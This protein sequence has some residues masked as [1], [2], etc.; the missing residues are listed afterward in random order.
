MLLFK[1]SGNTFDS[2]IANQKHAFKGHPKNWEAGEIILISKNKT[3]CKP[4]EKQIQYIMFL[5]NIRQTNHDE[6]EKYWPNN[7]KRWKYI[8]DCSSCLNLQKS[9]NILELVGQ[10]F[11]H[12]YG[13]VQTFKKKDPKHEVLLLNFL[14]SINALD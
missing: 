11:F 14:K 13:R 5:D 9:F 10:E 3:F 7:Q 1:T 12:D 2:V 8:A 6:F 4:K